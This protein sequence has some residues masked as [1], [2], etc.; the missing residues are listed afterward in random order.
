[1]ASHNFHGHENFI[2]V[3]KT[4]YLSMRAII[5]LKSV[6]KIFLSLWQFKIKI[7]RGR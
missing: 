1:M 4:F 2:P 5:L 7:Q 6:Q 3:E